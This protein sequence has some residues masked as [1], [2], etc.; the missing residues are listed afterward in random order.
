MEGLIY[1]FNAILAVS[2]RPVNQQQVRKKG[3]MKLKVLINSR[4]NLN[5]TSSTITWD[6]LK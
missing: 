4:D 5:K 1:L 3:M 6:L 2:H